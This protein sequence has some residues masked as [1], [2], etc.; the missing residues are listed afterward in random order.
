MADTLPI[1]ATSRTFK[2]EGFHNSNHSYVLSSLHDNDAIK[3]PAF[4][5]NCTRG[6]RA[7]DFI[8]VR[9][10]DFSYVAVLYVTSV[11][12]NVGITT[13]IFN[14]LDFKKDK[15][16]IEI[17]KY[18]A[19]DFEIG[20]IPNHKWRVI[21]KNSKQVISKNNSTKEDAEKALETF[22]QK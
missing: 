11:E 16:S 8:T 2:N 17:I 3:T 22:L 7:G 19:D 13:A 10:E 20:F 9:K 21:D 5:A 1:R 12:D 15:D 14:E 6:V 18:N 4:W